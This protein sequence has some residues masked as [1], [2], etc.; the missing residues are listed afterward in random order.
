MVE[1]E[2]E[3]VRFNENNLLVMFVTASK[4]KAQLDFALI[5]LQCLRSTCQISMEEKFVDYVEGEISKRL[6]DHYM[7]EV[8]RGD[9]WHVLSVKIM[10][11]HQV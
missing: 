1:V 11:L 9:S 10:G 7:M 2:L 4:I 8:V 5:S 6:S 3:Q